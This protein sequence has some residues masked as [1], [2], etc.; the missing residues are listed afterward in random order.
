MLVKGATEVNFSTVYSQYLAVIV[1]WNTSKRHTIARPW[2]R[3]VGCIL[4]LK[5]SLSLS[6]YFFS[7]SI[8]N[9]VFGV[10]TNIS[11]AQIISHKIYTW[12]DSVWFA[13]VI[14]S[15]NSGFMWCMC[16][17]S[18]GLVYWHIGKKRPLASKVTLKHMGNP[19]RHAWVNLA[20]NTKATNRE[21]YAFSC[22]LLTLQEWG[23]HCMHSHVYCRVI[24]VTSTHIV[25]GSLCDGYWG[26]DTRVSV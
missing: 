23:T 21:R 25:Q 13:M 17:Y 11:R 14:S 16:I 9:H 3:G 15:S 8:I 20:C 19:E 10:K 24:S 4:K 26:N 22:N 7:C 6:I 2:W 12:L 1:L 5:V 18:L